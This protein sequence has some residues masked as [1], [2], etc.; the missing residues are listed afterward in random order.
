MRNII[1]IPIA[2]F[3][4]TLIAQMPF[5]H[6][7]AC[8]AH[9]AKADSSCSSKSASCS[10]SERNDIIGTA[11]GAGQFNTLIAAVK[12]AGLVETLR[13]EGPFTIFA[14]TDK[15]FAKIPK[16]QLNALLKDKKALANILTYHVVPGAVKA[17]KVTKVS[18]A[19]AANGQ[20][21]HFAV[22]RKGHVM[23]EEAKV[24]KTDITASNGII[25][26]I[27]SVILPKDI[28]DRA[29][30][31]EDFST[32]VAAV[33]AAELVETLKG[34]GPFT[35]FAPVNSAFAK[36]PAGTVET[37]LKPENRGKLTDILTYHVVPGK[38]LAK[39]VVN[40]SNAKTVQGNE[41]DITVKGDAVHIDNAKVLKTDIVCD[42]GV[43]HIIDS[44]IVPKS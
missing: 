10:M 18:S 26:V 6:C 22:N 41:I 25:H 5:A 12:A 15:A 31:V 35:V 16:D 4:L 19:K 21:V 37:L 9:A 44:V 29:A 24:L 39:D 7:G 14:P 30:K 42:N 32:L 40:L 38:V 43:I 34:K 8:G 27:D 2:I 17:K 13:G 23:V 3:A 20:D 1:I 33:K 11:A 36:L 28:V